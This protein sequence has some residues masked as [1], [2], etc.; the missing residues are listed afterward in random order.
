MAPEQDAPNDDTVGKATENGDYAAAQK[1]DGEAVQNEDAV[2]NEVSTAQNGDAG[3]QPEMEQEPQSP[4]PG[5][6]V[7][8]KRKSS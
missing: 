2:Q 1:D 4:F 8:S 7:H 6:P 5:M 3:G